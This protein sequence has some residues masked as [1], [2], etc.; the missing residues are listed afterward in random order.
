MSEKSHFKSCKKKCEDWS[1]RELWCKRSPRVISVN[2]FWED[3]E[4]VTILK[5]LNQIPNYFQ[6]S[7]MMNVDSSNGYAKDY[8]Y[9]FKGAVFYWG[10]H[11]FDYLRYINSEGEKWA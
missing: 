2:L 11:Y 1:G 9:V 6:L 4:P 7:E 10:A 8:T 3:E 5:L